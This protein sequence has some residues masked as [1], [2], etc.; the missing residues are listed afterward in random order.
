MGKI[1]NKSD[2]ITKLAIDCDGLS[3]K[4]VEEAT[5]QVIDLMVDTLAKD[6]RVEVRGFGS[7]SLHHR[8]P[9]LARNPKTGQKVDVEATAI[10]HFKP[11]KAL[12]EAVNQQ[13]RS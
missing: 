13:R 1:L 10:P 11:G 2:L 8:A 3:E 6:G 4:V 9:R 7:F 5:K 12:R